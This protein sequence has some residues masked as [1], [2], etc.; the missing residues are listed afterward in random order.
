MFTK[1]GDLNPITIVDAVDQIDDTAT[2]A[3]LKKVIKAVKG[4]QPQKEIPAQIKK[5]SETK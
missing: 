4:K 1:I 2:R 3:S 5:E